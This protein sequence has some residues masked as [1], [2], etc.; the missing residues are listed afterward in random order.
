M[1]QEIIVLGG[2]AIACIFLIQRFWK[3]FFNK[4][5]SCSSCGISNT[6]ENKSKL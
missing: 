3:Q 2:I 6:I 5:D 1:I 4:K